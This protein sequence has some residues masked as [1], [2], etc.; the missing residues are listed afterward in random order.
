MLAQLNEESVVK[1][2]SQFWE[3]MLAMRLETM[4]FAEEFCVGAGHL[5]ASVNLSGQWAGSIEVRMEGSLAYAAT[6]AMM[7]QPIEAVAEADA[8]DATKEIANMIAGVIKSSLPR[9]CAMDVPESAVEAEGYCGAP[10][11]HD[12]LVVAFRHA[13]GDLMVCIREGERLH[14]K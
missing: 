4:P 3:Q 2:N 8:L 10:R 7:M 12:T 1:A 6:A 11:T 9:P 13:S 14:T 5:L